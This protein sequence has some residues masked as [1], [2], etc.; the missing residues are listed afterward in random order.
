V[1]DGV[2][3]TAHG[4]YQPA[5]VQLATVTSA[6]MTPRVAGAMA[7]TGAVGDQPGEVS[8]ERAAELAGLCAER[9]LDA[10]LQVLPVGSRLVRPLTMTV[11]VRSGSDFER[12]SE[13]ADG[14]SSVV[15]DR[16]GGGVPAR[17]AIGVCSLPGGSPVEV[18][19]SMEWAQ[20]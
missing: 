3:I 4:N 19:L 18:V 10:C 5:T 20:D 7:E 11:Y 12:H 14:A 9:A 16:V 2:L 13:V 6:G 17:A 1:T 8:V 15:A